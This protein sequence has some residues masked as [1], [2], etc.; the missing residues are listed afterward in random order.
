MGDM[1]VSP[2]LIRLFYEVW[3][4]AQIG[5]E[6][7]LSTELPDSVQKLNRSNAVEVERTL[8][9]L[10]RLGHLVVEGPL[11]GTFLSTLVG[12]DVIRIVTRAKPLLE[13]ARQKRE[14]PDHLAYVDKLYDVCRAKFPDYEPK[15]E[16][17]D[18]RAIGLAG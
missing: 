9:A 8:R 5:A 7:V 13:E 17:Q 16:S 2:E 18:R 11:E 14:D 1:D 4:E 15:Y 10:N 12:K 3:D 6:Y